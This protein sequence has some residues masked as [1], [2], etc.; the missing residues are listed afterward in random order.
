MAVEFAQALT[1]AAS[2]GTQQLS[3]AVL[4][5]LQRDSYLYW[6]FILSTAAIAF[7][8]AWRGALA[9]RGDGAGSAWQRFRGYLRARIWWHPSAR[10]D[11]RLYLANAL[12]VP[13]L[14]GVFALSDRDVTA[15]LEETF[16]HLDAVPDGA[17]APGVAA[18]VLF[19]LAFFIAY[20]FGRFVAH[21]LLHDVPFLWAFHKMHHAAQVL[22]PMTAYRAHP[23][24][25]LIMASVPALFT[26]IVTWAFHLLAG[27]QVGIYTFLG[28]HVFIWALN[29]VDN[30][31]HSHVWLTYGPALG[32][33]IVSPAHHQLHHSC[34]PEHL[35]CN[36]GFSIALWDRLYGTF[37]LPPERY[38]P[39]RMGLG[40]GSEP[41]WHGVLRSY[42]LPFV[43]LWKG[44][45][46]R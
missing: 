32:R 10:A 39:F 40:D 30:L 1:E 28:L 8:V 11:Y 14:F 7:L 24:E 12:V 13:L 27:A 19:T 26:G 6:P 2:Y 18:R 41:Q 31:R 38:A 21:C 17:S 20:D 9:T 23:V 45:A 5:F 36:R 34:E 3:L 33:W 37:R 4:A 35:N 25:L 46:R 29:L 22:T 15:F 42:V 44:Y 16:Q 43:D